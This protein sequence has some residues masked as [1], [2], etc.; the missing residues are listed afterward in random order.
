VIERFTRVDDRTLLYRFTIDDPST[1]T[2]PWTGEYSWSTSS[3]PIYE[4]ACR[5]GNYSM[6]D[7]LKGARLREKE[8]AAKGVKIK[9]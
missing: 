7:I 4:Y 5:E 2:K 8:E 1:W 6:K 3:G 9:E